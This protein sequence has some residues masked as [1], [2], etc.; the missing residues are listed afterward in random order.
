MATNK[1]IK[2]VST[3]KG[4]DSYADPTTL[5]DDTLR[6][7]QNMSPGKGSTYTREGLT[8]FD[9]TQVVSSLPVNGLG[10]YYPDTAHALELAVCNG[11]LKSSIGSGWTSQITDLNPSNL[12]K[13]EQFQDKALICDQSTDL[14]VYQH[15][16]V[17]ATDEDLNHKAG[18]YS[19][20]VS[21]LI[22]SFEDEALWTVDSG[23]TKLNDQGHHLHGKQSVKF[24][25]PLG[26]YTVYTTFTALDLNGSAVFSDGSSSDTDDYISLYITRGDPNLITSVRLILGDNTFSNTFY[27]DLS[28][29]TAWIEAT[30]T[31]G[32]LHLRLRKKYFQTLSGTPSWDTIAGVKFIVTTTGVT[33]VTLDWLRLEKSGPIAWELLKEI[34]NCETISDWTVSAGSATLGLNFQ[35]KMRGDASLSI[36]N[37]GNTTLIED[38]VSLDL[39]TFTD[40]TASAS[41]DDV[42]IYLGKSASTLSPTLQL[43]LYTEAGKYYYT[44]LV[45]SAVK[46]LTPFNISKAS[47]LLS[48]APTGWAIVKVGLYFA[49]AF[50][51]TVYVDAIS[52]VRHKDTKVVANFD[53]TEGWAPVTG[54]GSG[55]TTTW[56]T[57]AKYIRGDEG[58]T[59]SLYLS[60]RK[61]ATNGGQ[62]T[63]Y[64]TPATPLHLSTYSSGIGV[65]S[66]DQLGCYM[67]LP[68][69]INFGRVTLQLGPVGMAS[70]YFQKTIEK[71]DLTA[72]IEKTVGNLG[73]TEY[74]NAWYKLF[75]AISEWDSVGSPNWNSLAQL[76]V[77]LQVGTTTQGTSFLSTNAYFDSWMLKRSSELTGVYY[78]KLT[79]VDPDGNE[80]DGSIISDKVIARAASIYV[81]N[82]PLVDGVNYKRVSSRRL[83]R[84]GGLLSEWGLV[85]TLDDNSR[86][87]F[88][89]ENLDS[90]ITGT[91]EDIEGQPFIPK[92]FCIH[93]NKVVMANLTS[94]DNQV[95]PS[96]VMVSK[97]KSCDVFDHEEFFEIESQSGGQIRWLL[98]YL[99]FVF[100]GKDDSIWKFDPYNLDLSPSLES[101]LYGGVG[102]LACC[103]GENAFFFLDKTGVISY[104]GSYFQLISDPIQNY[105]DEIP[106]VYLSSC[107]M[108]YFNETLLIGI[109]R[110]GG[111]YP[112]TILSCYKPESPDR[113]WSIISGWNVGC[114]T[115]YKSAGEGSIFHLGSATNGYVWRAF[116]GDTDDGS[117]IT[118]ILWF[119][120]DSYQQ[121]EIGKDFAKLFL[122]GNKETSTD[123]PLTIEPWI[124][125]ADSDVN[126][127]ETI[128]GGSTSLTSTLLDK[129]EIS[130]TQFG[131]FPSYLG[132]KITATKRWN[133]RELV[134]VIRLKEPTY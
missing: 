98:S 95:Y 121:P 91:F 63:A 9:S 120:D 128:Q 8:K 53:Q 6:L 114:S 55:V 74:S 45:I 30:N 80:S 50:T 94:P 107:W 43:R 32:S 108:E 113:S 27:Y 12:C 79:F 106:V 76:R 42:E 70:D 71:A 16:T 112:T 1:L 93:N 51:G 82:L 65:Q 54:S 134:S 78:Y 84:L 85:G 28:F 103:K 39:T 36:T 21:K 81:K 15:Y 109:V 3:L 19:P 92:T 122:F 22:T 47:F 86:E 56:T 115:S 130:G 26:T 101:R 58:S 62:G 13:I 11:I 126:L 75:F 59:Q 110:S 60:L 127:T 4:M 61:D 124:D 23:V 20:K 25:Y 129:L 87:V 125:L 123:V 46:A 83:Y 116:Y 5:S 104:N 131:Y 119:K 66:T 24:T 38:T 69:Y 34:N 102:L 77:T 100:V 90:E 96:G 29:T 111:T 64:Y 31:Y 35:Y 18:V 88:I 89:D 52:L 133:F 17:P 48:G 40:G 72:Y 2:R 7:I 10:R 44:D 33:S 117:D 132:L 57:S 67:F 68:S 99:N 14:R 41:I 49:S 37:A 118:S 97:E 73:Q 105:I